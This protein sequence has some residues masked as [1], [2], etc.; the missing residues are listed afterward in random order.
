MDGDPSAA[1][2]VRVWFEAG[3]Q[4]FRCRITSLD[5]TPGRRDAEEVTVALTSSAG[6]VVGAVRAWLD[7]VLRDASDGPER[8]QVHQATAVAEAVSEE[9]RH[10]DP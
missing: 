10:P 3:T 4:S 7:D 8:G 5:T 6:D 2:L 1:L 9:V